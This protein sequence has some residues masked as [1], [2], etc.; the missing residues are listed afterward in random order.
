MEFT[1]TN[2]TYEHINSQLY[3]IFLLQSSYSVLQHIPDLVQPKMEW[4]QLTKLQY[5]T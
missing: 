3:R 2:P 5:A 1:F 4:L